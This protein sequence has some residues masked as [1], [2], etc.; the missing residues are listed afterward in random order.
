[1]KLPRPFVR[2]PLRLPVQALQAELAALPA[3]AWR[4]HPQGF[5]GNDAVPL[6][7]HGGDPADDRPFGEMAETPWLRAC[8]A[9]RATL[10]ALGSPVGRTRLMRLAPGAEVQ[11]HVD[12]HPYWWDHLRVHVPLRTSPEV[13]FYCGYASAHMAE[14]EAW[15]FDTWRPHRVVNGGDTWRVHLVCDTI[16]SSGLRAFVFDE[17]AMPPR[18]APTRTDQALAVERWIAPARLSTQTLERALAL[19]FEDEPLRDTALLHLAPLRRG[20]EDLRAGWAELDATQSAPARFTALRDEVHATLERFEGRFQLRNRVD[21]VAALRRHVL[22]EALPSPPAPAPPPRLDRP[23]AVVC[24]PRSGSGL[25]FEALQRAPGVYSLGQ[26]SHALIDAWPGLHPAARGFV[27]HALPA[28]DTELTEA[29]RAEL[30]AAL[31]DR[32]QRPPPPGLPIRVVEKTPKSCLRLPLLEALL[33]EARYLLLLREPRDALSSLLDAWRAQRFVTLPR[34]PGWRNPEGLAWSFLLTPGWRG[35]VD[36]P[37]WRV[38]AEQWRVAAEQLSEALE[39]L[40]PERRLSVRHEALVT[41]PA[42][43]LTALHEALGLPTR[44]IEGPLPLSQTTLTPPHPDKWRRNAAE[45]E[46]ALPLVAEAWAQLQAAAPP[47]VQ[48]R[49]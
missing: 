13:L 46:L 47:L 36:V 4:P 12:T 14:G 19:L 23:I 48:E 29:L 10:S 22:A 37:L 32:D 41:Q 33:P 20:L 49:P 11:E 6:I 2:L 31:R 38:V 35:L 8:P 15:V 45:L 1:M 24:P 27:S 17:A 5:A 28:L 7:S 34:L 21:P 44:P 30:I 18:S 42:E 3:E 26:E 16:G 25:L 39:E 40:P 9:M 43:V